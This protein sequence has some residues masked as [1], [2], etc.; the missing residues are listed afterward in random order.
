IRF[1]PSISMNSTWIPDSLWRF[2]DQS[3]VS[4]CVF[5]LLFLLLFFLLSILV[6]C[7]IR[8]RRSHSYRVSYRAPVVSSPHNFDGGTIRLTRHFSHSTLNRNGRFS[9]LPRHSIVRLPHSDTLIEYEEESPE[10][11]L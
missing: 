2:D 6:F 9:T 10:V 7:C 11:Y 8:R 5:S 1:P 4:I 3:E